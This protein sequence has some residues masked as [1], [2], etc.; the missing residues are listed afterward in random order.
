MEADYPAAH[1]M[2]TDF[3]AVDKDGRVATF[4]SGE[5][6]AVPE[7]ALHGGDTSGARGWLAEV[8]PRCELLYVRGGH[9]LPGSPDKHRPAS[10]SRFV[11]QCLMFL[12]SLEPVQEEI[13]AGR[14]VVVPASRGAAVWI[15]KVP[16]GVFQNLHDSGTCRGCYGWFWGPPD[17]D[18]CDLSAFGVYHYHHLEG[19]AANPY[20]QHVSPAQ[21]VHVDQLPPDLRAL[22][23]RLRVDVSFAETPLLQPAEHWA[24]T[25][26]GTAY[27]DSTGKV[28]RP[29]KGR[30]QL[31]REYED[32]LRAWLELEEPGRYQ[33]ESPPGEE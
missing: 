17:E 5:N 16:R 33:V 14:V 22:V 32:S 4:W 2:D 19:P 20:G 24:C 25:A 31:F 15:K 1:S 10:G 18:G 6:G 12:D 27:L 13:A 29:L 23:S 21:A 9:C 30:E 8:L 7:S 26:Y 11:S 3:F 28:I